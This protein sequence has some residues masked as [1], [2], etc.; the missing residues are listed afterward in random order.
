MSSY[1]TWHNLLS[2]ISQGSFDKICIKDANGVMTDLLT[3]IG[4]AT[5]AAVNSATAPLSINNGV[6]S[7]N[8]TG[9]IPTSH[10]SY[11]V[12]QANVNFGAYDARTQTLT[13]ENASGFTCQLNVD[14]GGNL[15][16][17]TAGW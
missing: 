7:I 3:L 16:V 8:L 17:G 13:L 15:N 6:L 14:L 12:G 1:D 4:A 5:G 11:N 10:E 2:G 9:Y